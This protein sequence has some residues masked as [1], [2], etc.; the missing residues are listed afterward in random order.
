[1][2]YLQETLTN[3]ERQ[4]YLFEGSY[5]EDT[6]PYGNIIK[7]WDGFLI[8]SSSGSALSAAVGANG[9]GDKRARKFRE[10]DRLFSRSSVTSVVSSANMHNFY[11]S[12][13][14]KLPNLSST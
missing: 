1:M 14:R 6:A 9:S 10:S 8:T 5:L 3:L 7:G 12:D 4:I 2:L 11:D 13:K